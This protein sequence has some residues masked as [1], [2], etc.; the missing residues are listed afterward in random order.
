LTVKGLIVSVAGVGSDAMRLVAQHRGDARRPTV[1][2]LSP[3]GETAS[4]CTCGP[5]D[6]SLD[7]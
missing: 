3:P 7:D 1:P 2:L 5:I 4:T 6:R